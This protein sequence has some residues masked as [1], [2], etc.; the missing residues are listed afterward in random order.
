[1]YLFDPDLRRFGLKPPNGI[2]VRDISGP[3]GLGVFAL[4]DFRPGMLVEVSPVV[5]LRVPFDSLPPAIQD[6]VFNWDDLT[7]QTGGAHALP[8]GYGCLY[9]GDN[10]ANLRYE[11]VPEARTFIQFIAARLISTGEELTVNY[12]GPKGAAESA[13]D[14]WFDRRAIKR[15]R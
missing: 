14:W 13:D 4:R 7:G 3:K 8:L 12:S 9:N 10:P 11:A 1:M 2:E 15:S 6:R 5:L